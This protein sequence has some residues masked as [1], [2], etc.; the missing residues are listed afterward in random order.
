MSEIEIIDPIRQYA[1]SDDLFASAYESLNDLQRGW[2]KKCI[3]QLCDWYHNP[4]QDCI[5]HEC[6]WRT[7][8]Y[9]LSTTQP[10][11]WALILV[12]Q[13]LPSPSQVLAASLPPMLA[14]VYEIF[15]I[16]VNDQD[17]SNLGTLTALELSGIENVFHCPFSEI[18]KFI[19]SLMGTQEPGVVISLGANALLADHL[20]S[21]LL[22]PIIRFVHLNPPK[23]MALWNEGSQDWHFEV[24]EFIHPGMIFEIWGEDN[25]YLPPY[26]SLATGDW[27]Q[28]LDQGYDT[29]YVPSGSIREAS[30]Y[31]SMVLGP[32]QESCWL[33][34]GFCLDVCYS[35]RVALSDKRL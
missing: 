4:T 20:R 35:E 16:I 5:S 27:F 28:F 3:A 6:V 30:R 17:D 33:W 32:G 34:P 7:G 23:K 21:Y 12:N 22:S 29:L 8:F 2:L 19:G 24:L 9:S 31:A 13:N 18:A 11:R 1:V 26:W 10:R 25:V 14:G 15:V